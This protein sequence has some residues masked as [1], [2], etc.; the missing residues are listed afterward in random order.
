MV[1]AAWTKPSPVCG[2]RSRSPG[3]RRP[4]PWCSISL[5]ATASR[6]APV[7][8]AA[9]PSFTSDE[10]GEGVPRVGSS[11]HGRLRTEEPITNP[12]EKPSTLRATSAQARPRLPAQGKAAADAYEGDPDPLKGAKTLLAHADSPSPSPSPSRPTN[13][14]RLVVAVRCRSSNRLTLQQPSTLQDALH[15]IVTLM[16]RVLIDLV[17]SS[18]P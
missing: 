17:V 14:Y 13:R 3:L 16:T 8:N 10:A 18:W 6:V 12:L 11:S 2:F 1:W 7:A 4:A 5:F 9:R 15:R